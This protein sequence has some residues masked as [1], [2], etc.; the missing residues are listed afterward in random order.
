MTISKYP[1]SKTFTLSEVNYLY[2]VTKPLSFRALV[3][4]KIFAK[5]AAN[6]CRKRIRLQKSLKQ[7]NDF[8]KK[9]S[10]IEKTRDDFINLQQ[11]NADNFS[12]KLISHLDLTNEDL[13]KW[14]NS[15]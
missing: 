4:A 7:Y 6:L 14:L 11:S 10:H 3:C 8:L 1:K 2:H 5:R 15:L 13:Q 9:Q 12:S